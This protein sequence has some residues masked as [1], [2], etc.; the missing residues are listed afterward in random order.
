[1]A[2]KWAIDLA[3][4]VAQ[5]EGRPQPPLVKWRRL[6]FWS[7]EHSSGTSYTTENKIVITAGKSYKDQKL[8]LLHEL[9]HWLC[10]T[11][12]HHSDRFWDKAFGLYRRYNIPMKYALQREGNYK[13]RAKQA[14]RRNVD[15]HS[16]DLAIQK[17]EAKG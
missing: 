4:K 17:A 6:K 9:A 7:P 16:A 10:D 1:M 3:S 12:E 14:Y 13:E 2:P 15:R 11:N 5:D 8:V